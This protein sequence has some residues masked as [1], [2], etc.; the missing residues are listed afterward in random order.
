V[1]V[2]NMFDRSKI[3]SVTLSILCALVV[4][5]LVPLGVGMVISFN[6]ERAHLKDVLFHYQDTALES[7]AQGVEDDLL[8]FSPDGA[9]DL[10]NV[11]L[12]DER[13]VSITVYSSVFEMFLVQIT[14]QTS[15]QRYMSHS[16]RK[17]I[18]KN[19]EDLGYVE[20]A[21]DY[22]WIEPVM[23]VSRKRTM[24]LFITMFVGVMALIIPFLYFRILKPLKRLSGQAE[25]LSNGDLEFS[26]EWKGRNELSILG[27]TLEDMRVK[28]NANFNHI[29]KMA[30]T[31]ELTGIAN[32]RAFFQ[33][34]QKLL[35]LCKRHSHSYSLAILDIDWFKKIN[36][37]HGHSVGDEVLREFAQLIA[38]RV[39]KTDV[40][41]RYG[42]EEF[43]LCMPETSLPAA[44]GLLEKLRREIAEHEFS[45]GEKLTFSVGLAE[46]S[47]V[48]SLAFV[49]EQADLALYDAKHKGR[50]RIVTA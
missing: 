33:E 49:L 2:G 30:V 10:A 35:E 1:S 13:V 22:G 34:A 23:D 32:R 45:H 39:R 50:N 44:L 41:A 18:I 11:F 16:R 48:S 25:Q 40:F 43:V 24:A 28:L 14:K 26:C 3:H 36:D 29:L 12:K 31:D 42:G 38:G 9:L 37:N 6:T 8:S 27:R 15:V 47:D 5:L 20:I 46:M 4:G 19:G 21:V 7:L 17:T